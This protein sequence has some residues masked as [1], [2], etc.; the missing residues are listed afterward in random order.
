MK[1]EKVKGDKMGGQRKG[2]WERKGKERETE[3]ER[4]KRMGRARMRHGT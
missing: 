1:R 3:R 4:V 2:I